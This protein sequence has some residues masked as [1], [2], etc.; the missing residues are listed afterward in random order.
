MTRALIA[1][2]FLLLALPVA[3]S[4]HAQLESTSPARGAT[5][6]AQPRTVELAFSEAVEGSF[7]AVRVFDAKAQRVDDNT[8]LHPQGTQSKL[9]VGLQPDLPD[10]TYTATYR[11]ISADG[12][13]VSGGLVFS[14]GQPGA[15]P[16][17]TVDELIGATKAGP[18][19]RAT[20][21]VANGLQYLATALAAGLLGFLLLCWRPAQQLVPPAAETAFAARAK[22]V[23]LVAVGLGL[24]ASVLGIVAEG[25]IA[26]GVSFTSA[27]D[28]TIISD[29]IHTRYGRIW[30][31]RTVVWAV[32][33]VAALVVFRPGQRTPALFAGT[34]GLLLAIAPALEGHSATQSPCW[35]LVPL[36]ALHV[37]A[38]TV[39][40]GGLASLLLLVP[41]ATATLPAQDRSKLL[42][43]LL[44]RFSPLALAAV[45]TL[46]VT[47]TIA[48]VEF[49]TQVS[50]LWDIAYG[51]EILA[52]I[53]LL[54]LLAGLG[55]VNRRRVIPQLRRL[56]DAG[57]A[58]G[59]AGRV[60]RDT[61]R[62]EVLLVVAVLG[63]SGVLVDGIPP[64]SAASGP[65]TRTT[66]LGPLDLQ[67][68]VDPARTGAN[69]MHLYLFNPKD[70]SQFTGTKEITATV[71]LPAK[72]I[73]PLPVTLRPTGPGHYTADTI[74]FVPAGTWTLSIT[75][76][77]SD[78]DQ[79]STT[80]EIP[81]R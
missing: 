67:L 57:E 62:I 63:V 31:A 52:K 34:A 66:K 80:M 64:V 6:E 9:A 41:R 60:L 3:A 56:A 13:P 53:A 29:V 1:V 8:V 22:A 23:L 65:F 73:G 75:D 26:A 15:G 45:L 32:L 25:A 58:P 20:S 69:E 77:V 48:A 11:V 36:D 37:I 4:A 14:I 43:A 59:K 24:V 21:R 50:Q 28:H 12:H 74:Q 17:K 5:L 40:L 33:L 81:I 19:T 42:V 39:W 49:L 46:A 70:G 55:H 44:A 61:L 7:G 10:G 18:F 68:T 2:A 16:A 30:G 76:R 78:F 35:L 51:R 72:D 27:I 54:G 47:G 71:S 79:Y 38:M